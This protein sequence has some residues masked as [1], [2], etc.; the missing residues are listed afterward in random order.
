MRRTGLVR[1][2]SPPTTL[3]RDFRTAIFQHFDSLNL[4]H[5]SRFREL[6]ERRMHLRGETV[7]MLQASVLNSEFG[8]SSGFNPL[9]RS[10]RL[11]AG[12]NN[13]RLNTAGGRS[14][15]IDSS[16]ETV[17]KLPQLPDALI[18]GAS[19]SSHCQSS[20]VNPNNVALSNSLHG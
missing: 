6:P 20:L 1:H 10:H 19:A 2:V 9:L 14:T 17:H 16:T 18:V 7:R 4:L 8:N 13:C 15:I 11:K 3:E 12:G 5:R